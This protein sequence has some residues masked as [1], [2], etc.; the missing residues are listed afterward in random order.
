[1]QRRIN[2]WRKDIS[3]LAENGVGVDNGRLNMIKKI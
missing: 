2:N 1:M 3:I